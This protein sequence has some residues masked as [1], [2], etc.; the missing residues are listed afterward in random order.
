MSL[1][2]IET[3]DVDG[4][5]REAEEKV[6]GDTRASFFKK[7]AVGGGAVLGSG[8]F[9]GMLPE[10]ALGK[11]S[12]KQDLEILNYALTLEFLEAE[13]YTEAVR[14]GDLRGDALRFAK[15]VGK[16]ER[17]HVVA[18]KKTIKSLGGKP[19]NKPKFDFKGSNREQKPFIQTALVLENTGVHAYLGQVDKIKSSAIL[20]AAAQIATVEGRHAAAIATILGDNEYSD[21]RDT[22]ITPDGAF[23]VPFSMK[24]VLKAVDKTNFI[25]G[26]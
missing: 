3:L 2:N 21:K 9:M 19:V 23:D 1:P 6:A 16:H 7:A 10:L 12:K 8:A 15:I 20:K 5:I 4:A 25:K 14:K 22:S 13:F 24:K 18:L 17:I 11:P 26:F